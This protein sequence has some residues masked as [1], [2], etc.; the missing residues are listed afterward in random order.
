V[1]ILVWED[2]IEKYI[3]GIAWKSVDWIYLA[4]VRDP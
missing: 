1:K 4:Q 3:R 2:N